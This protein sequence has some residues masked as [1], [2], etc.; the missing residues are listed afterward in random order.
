ME[1]ILRESPADAELLSDMRA[2]RG[3]VIGKA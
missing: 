3:Q 2:V 1:R